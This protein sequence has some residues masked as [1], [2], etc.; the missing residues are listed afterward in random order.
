MKS[1]SSAH[2]QDAAFGVPGLGKNPTARLA[3]GRVHAT[4]L[5]LGLVV[6]ALCVPRSS[7]A[8]LT[9]TAPK[10][11][12]VADF[13]L[14]FAEARNQWTDNSELGPLME[15]M[16]R[17]EPGGGLQGT[18]KADEAVGRFTVL[19]N[20]LTY[21]V[22]D[23]VSAVLAV[24]VVLGGQVNPNLQ[25]EPGD[26][27]PTLGRPYSESDFWAWAGSMGQ[28]RPG[29][30]TGLQGALSDIVLASRWR[31]SDL[32]PPEK[33]WNIDLALTVF[34]AL[35]TGNEGDPEEIAA[36]GA[37]S[38]NFH[39][40]GELGIHLAA[41]K[42][43][44]DR[45]RFGGDV[46]YQAFLRR[47]YTAADG[48]K[49]PLLLTESPYVGETYHMNPGDFLG[50]R[51]QAQAILFKGPTWQTWLSRRAGGVDGL[52]PMLVFSAA[53]MYHWVGASDFQSDSPLWDWEQESYWARGFRQ[54]VEAQLTFSL[55]RLGV[56]LDL[57]GIY[58]DHS[59]LP[60]KNVRASRIFG[61]GL[62]APLKFW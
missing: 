41:E 2:A 29:P 56:P 59:L 35:P 17:Y 60:G 34:G 62:R 7:W 33:R 24:P 28:P 23:S 49:H 13:Q 50:A 6:L 38:W 32:I 39:F 22:T 5:C 31:F 43:F 11:M 36:L 30:W 21:G 27:S 57:Y 55:M 4:G 61:G 46:F 53:Y 3:L 58:R 26:Y 18:I 44:F 47:E 15:N 40:Q 19:V 16:E 48:D 10:D 25:W 1:F 42:S 20:R 45:L 54:R 14:N 52:P 12:F 9:Q 51:V 8:Q 37:T